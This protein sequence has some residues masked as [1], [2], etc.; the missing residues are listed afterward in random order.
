MCMSDN[1]QICFY[2]AGKIPFHYLCMINI[3][4]QS[5]TIH[6]NLINYF[7]SSSWIKIYQLFKNNKYDAIVDFTGTISAPIIFIAWLTKINKRIIF[8]RNSRYS[9]RNTF[10][11]KIYI[12][13]CMIINLK[14]SKF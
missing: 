6:A 9:F 12:R 4:L 8:Y 11:R 7:P 5:K 3:I 10:F 13:M 14:L 2:C 1:L